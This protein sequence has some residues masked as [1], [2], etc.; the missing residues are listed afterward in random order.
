V[1]IGTGHDGHLVRECLAPISS[2][3]KPNMY[4]LL[5]YLILSLVYLAT[6][7]LAGAFTSCIPDDSKKTLN[8][9][10]AIEILNRHNEWLC[11]V[12]AF[13]NGLATNL[14]N[15]SVARSKPN[16][17]EPPTFC[18]VD[19]TAGK[20]KIKEVINEFTSL[21]FSYSILEDADFSGA[22][23]DVVSFRG[24]CLANADFSSTSLWSV[25][26]DASN[27][28]QAKFV[29]SNMSA[30]SFKDSLIVN[31]DFSGSKLIPVNFA[32]AVYMASSDA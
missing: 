22:S 1:S 12:N 9:A 20:W 10:E 7:N 11:S 8:T 2:L 5:S 16:S 25:D 31:T 30:T 3:V 26:L 32:G 19:F 6:T 21:D 24:A 18:N 27:L 23:L 4:R 13:Q 29:K 14:Y 15:L 17:N 28:F